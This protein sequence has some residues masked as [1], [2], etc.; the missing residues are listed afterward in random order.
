MTLGKEI[1]RPLTNKMVQVSSHFYANLTDH[2]AESQGPM[3]PLG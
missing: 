3:R 1:N 2:H